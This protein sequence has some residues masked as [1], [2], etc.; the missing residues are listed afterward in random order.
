[1]VSRRPLWA[2]RRCRY[3]GRRAAEAL[4]QSK[5]LSPLAAEQAPPS[6][7]RTKRKNVEIGNSKLHWS[8]LR[9]TVLASLRDFCPQR[10]GE[11]D[12]G[13]G[14]PALHVYVPRDAN[15]LVVLE[16]QGQNAQIRHGRSTGGPHWGVRTARAIA[17]RTAGNRSGAAAPRDPARL[18]C[19]TFVCRQKEPAPAEATPDVSQSQ[20]RASGEAGRLTSVPAWHPARSSL[21]SGKKIQAAA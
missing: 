10:S 8:E 19:A 3:R 17:R 5:R 14:D 11:L 2:F 13:D 6:C 1:L 16:R 7:R 20:L 15:G 12:P 21:R 4:R 9:P 18:R